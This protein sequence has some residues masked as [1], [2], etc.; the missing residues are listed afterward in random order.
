[1][2]PVP[3]QHIPMFSVDGCFLFESM[4]EFAVF[5]CLYFVRLQK[6]IEYLGCLVLIF[7]QLVLE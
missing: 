5:Q 1:M 2:Q 7:W 3:G 6:Q 4:V